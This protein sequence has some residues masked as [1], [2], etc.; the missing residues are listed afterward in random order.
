MYD[1][2]FIFEFLLRLIGFFIEIGSEWKIAIFSSL[3]A[4][5]TTILGIYLTIKHNEKMVSKQLANQEEQY[6]E[7]K[8][9]QIMPFISYGLD[10]TDET[11]HLTH[12]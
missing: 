5:A 2:L 12:N 10:E 11:S 6:S 3:F 4:S 9:M 1:S 8:R 7:S